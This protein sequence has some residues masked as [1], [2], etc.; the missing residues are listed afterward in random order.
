MCGQLSGLMQLGQWISRWKNFR[1]SSLLFLKPYLKLFETKKSK[2]PLKLRLWLIEIT[3]WPPNMLCNAQGSIA[4]IIRWFPF[5]KNARYRVAVAVRRCN[6][7]S[8]MRTV[9]LKLVRSSSSQIELH[10]QKRKCKTTANSTEA[11]YIG[12][13]I[14]HWVTAKKKS[15]NWRTK[16]SKFIRTT[17]VTKANLSIWAERQMGSS[18]SSRFTKLTR[19]KNWPSLLL[20]RSSIKSE[21]KDWS[22]FISNTNRD[23]FVIDDIHHQII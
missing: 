9:S 18:R 15:R 10:K 23:T 2:Q 16:K 21:G 7:C 5:F 22:I 4:I 11:K 3:M 13:V 17:S 6:C 19:Q 8:S 14:S 12:R 20:Q 1:L